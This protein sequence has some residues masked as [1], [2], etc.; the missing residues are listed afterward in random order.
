MKIISTIAIDHGAKHTGYF[1][2]QIIQNDNGELSISPQTAKVISIGDNKAITYNQTTR[3]TKRHQIRGYK[4]RKMVKRLIKIIT[5]K[6]FE[7]DWNQFDKNQRDWIYGLFNRRG[8]SYL[9]ENISLKEIDT[10]FDV[11]IKLFVPDLDKITDLE[12]QFALNKNKLVEILKQFENTFSQTKNNKTQLNK[13][14]LQSEIVKYNPEMGEEEQKEALEV[15][16]LIK[17]WLGTQIDTL[18][19]GHKHRSE[20]FQDL[21]KMIGKCPLNPA[22]FNGKYNQEAFWKLCCNLSNFQLKVLRRYFQNNGN[23]LWEPERLHKIVLRWLKSWHFTGVEKKQQFIELYRI[24]NDLRNKKIVEFLVTTDPLKLIPPYEDLNNRNINP[25]KTLLIDPAFMNSQYPGWRDMV[26]RMIDYEKAQNNR[27][28]LEGTSCKE[29]TLEYQAQILQ[30]ILDRSNSIDPYHIRKI[31]R[32]PDDIVFSET[33]DLLESVLGD[34][35]LKNLLFDIATKYYDENELAASGLWCQ[36]DSGNML[37]LCGS[38]TR[39]KNNMKPELLTQLLGIQFD[40][41]KTAQFLSDWDR[42][43]VGRSTVKRIAEN[44]Y[45]VIKKLGNGFDFKLNRV[46]WKHERNESLDK[47]EAALWKLYEQSQGALGVIGD[48]LAMDEYAKS[49]IMSPYT[50]SQ[51]YAH[52]MK[53]TSGFMKTCPSCTQE[54]NWRMTVCPNDKHHSVLC[55]RLPADSIDLIDGIL[56]RMLDRQALEISRIK[57]AELQKLNIGKNQEIQVPIFIEEN[58]FQFAE[59]MNEIKQRKNLDLDDFELQ[60]FQDKTM[61]I[62]KAGGNICPYTGDDIGDYGEID[63]I[64]SRSLTTQWSDLIF[65]SEANLIYSSRK[66]NQSK[67]KKR[68][69]L[70]DLSPRYLKALFQTDQVDVIRETIGRKLLLLSGSPGN[71]EYFRLDE[72]TQK[73]LRHAL[74]IPDQELSQMEKDI[75]NKYLHTAVASRV[76]GTQG[77]LVRAIKRNLQKEWPLAKV[78][79]KRLKSIDVSML[80]SQFARQYPEFE[81]QKS[82]GIASHVLDAFFVFWK[83]LEDKRIFFNCFNDYLKTDILESRDFLKTLLPESVDIQLVKRQPKFARKTGRSLSSTPI[84]K[85]GIYAERFVP[86]WYHAG[87]LHIG[88]NLRDSVEIGEAFVNQWLKVLSP[89]LLVNRKPLSQGQDELMRSPTPFRLS[90]HKTKAFELFEKAAR[91]SLQESESN[92]FIML[93]GLRYTIQKINI[94]D[95]LFDSIKKVFSSEADCLKEEDFKIKLE[96]KGLDRMLFGTFPKVELTAPFKR[97]WER[98]TAYPPLHRLLGMKEPVSFDWNQLYRDLFPQHGS[99]IRKKVRTVFSLPR[100]KNPSGGFRIKRKSFDR[101]IS[102]YQL[103]ETEGFSTQGFPLDQDNKP[104]IRKDQSVPMKQ[105]LASRNITAQGQEKQEISGSIIAY[106]EWVEIQL[107]EQYR[108]TIQRLWISPGTQDR[109]VYKVQIGMEFFRNDLQKLLKPIDGNNWWNIPSILTVDKL[110]EFEVLFNGSGSRDKLMV[111]PKSKLFVE[112]LGKEKLTFFY[113]PE[114]RVEYA[115][116]L[117]QEAWKKQ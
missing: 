106:D 36:E 89:F 59:G 111:K 37:R 92:A 75:L 50:L 54:N 24:I 20:Y 96:M 78:S 76:N 9:S 117:F 65:N 84:F 100:I 116:R 31:C 28:I 67:G 6:V 33:H 87:Q 72:E 18:D 63:H 14:L 22:M 77:Y 104:I 60:M 108:S 19:T 43:V 69:L 112:S 34:V 12:S 40:E 73:C 105:L 113:T 2:S 57:K 103:V 26:N 45:N 32:N 64:I 17:K 90:I 5:E 51:L 115:T 88:F 52:F 1:S 35:G 41:N 70:R 62:R 81:K 25:C 66:G 11:I 71:V 3:R 99:D 101:Q 107:P 58:S 7:W 42:L 30:R 110:A 13:K 98:L 61:R 15:V 16:N 95:F 86:L 55:K 23:D 83:A 80:R 79:A 39:R 44:I 102:T 49:K 74:F 93:T 56:V 85:E 27:L 82:Q 38:K 8:F 21:K 97:D 4:R 91:E 94:Q 29:G 46:L 48:T 109:F 47:D 68:A 10:E 114:N 53:D